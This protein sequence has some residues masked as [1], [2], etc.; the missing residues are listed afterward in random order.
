MGYHQ[1]NFS[2]F[3]TLTSSAWVRWALVRLQDIQRATWTDLGWNGRQSFRHQESSLEVP[4]ELSHSGISKSRTQILRNDEFHHLSAC[5]DLHITSPV[6]R[7][8]SIIQSSSY[9]NTRTLMILLLGHAV[10]RKQRLKRSIE[11][12]PPWRSF[13]KHQNKKMD[14]TATSIGTSYCG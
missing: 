1:A 10:Q 2:N 14:G 3:L 13:G 8:S 7:L 5:H 6:W 12:G 11:H 9:L 4:F